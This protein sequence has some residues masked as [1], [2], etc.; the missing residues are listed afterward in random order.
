MTPETIEDLLRQSRGPAP[1]DRVLEA[2]ESA[3]RRRESARELSRIWKWIPMAAALSAVAALFFAIFQTGPAAAPAQEGAKVDE[4]GVKRLVEGLGAETLADR[5]DAAD[6]LVKLGRAVRP[7]LA[8]ELAAA[9]DAEVRARILRVLDRLADIVI[10]A[11]ALPDEEVA[12]LVKILKGTAADR[13]VG[14]FNALESGLSTSAEV[15]VLWMSAGQKP[16][17]GKLIEALRGRRVIG[18]G[19]GAG[20]LFEA[21]RLEIN[22]GA[23]AGSNIQRIVLGKGLKVADVP[24]PL[25]AFAGEAPD[26]DC[27]NEGMHLPSK[28]PRTEFV[29]ALA[30]WDGDLNYVPLARQ[31]NFVLSGIAV[32]PGTWTEDF[33][34]VFR[35]VAEDLMARPPMRT[36]PAAWP[37]TKPGEYEI[38]LAAGGSETE[39]SGRT[40]FVRFTKP[41]TMKLHLKH[42]GSEAMMLITNGPE[43]R[44]WRR[45]DAVAREGEFGGDDV[46]PG[47]DISFELDVTQEDVDACRKDYLRIRVTNFDDKHRAKGRLKI[48]FEP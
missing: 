28:D 25:P 26:D 48:E 8:R 39:L 24:S 31:G 13:H 12:K 42:E 47:E 23:C 11:P 4:A 33:A 19:D 20:D 10:F 43:R 41:T 32:P 44:L 1:S 5:D 35:K 9:T 16:S 30:R 18:I 27:P 14:C 15:L 7:L 38:D 36:E 29:E 3:V 22:S 34:R 6:A 40:F 17:D 45:R 46:P 21:M 37:L 2:L